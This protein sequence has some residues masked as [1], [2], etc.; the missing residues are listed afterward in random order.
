MVCSLP[1]DFFA[2]GIDHL[3]ST[4]H[5]VALPPKQS[6]TSKITLERY[7]IPF[8]IQPNPDI[9][10]ECLPSCTDEKNPPKYEAIGFMEWFQG[11]F[12]QVYDTT[13]KL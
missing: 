2:D 6:S 1:C 13:E 12:K 11:K 7:S 10:I 4:L 5:G 3:R 8:F 9:T